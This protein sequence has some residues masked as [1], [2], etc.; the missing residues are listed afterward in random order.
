M[1]FFYFVVSRFLFFRCPLQTPFLISEGGVTWTEVEEGMH[2][3]FKKDVQIR[4]PTPLWESTQE[5]VECRQMLAFV[6]YAF[7]MNEVTWT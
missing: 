6:N 5:S 1:L 4:N 7:E 2:P 3:V